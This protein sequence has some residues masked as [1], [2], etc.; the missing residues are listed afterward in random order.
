MNPRLVAVVLLALA[1]AA[2]TPWARV[3]PDTRA[4]DKRSDYTLDLP[5]GWVKR[6]ADAN[7]LFLTR[8]GPALNFILVA[9]QP[10]DRKLPRTKRETRADM[11]PFELAELALAEWKSS[12]ATANLEVLAN[13]PATLG[14][15]PAARLHI[16][17]KNERGLPIERLLIA[18][19]DAKGR[20]SFLYEAPAI[21]YFQRGLADFEAMVA[22]VRFQ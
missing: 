18:R 14:G 16:R 11:L 2:C 13:T 5:L 15:Q 3:A 19:I 1:L 9:R 7:D 17:Y 12:E 10:H 6:T 4:Y 21:V 20:L 22:S 8:D